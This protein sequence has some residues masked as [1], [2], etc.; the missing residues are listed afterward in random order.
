VPGALA[1]IRAEVGTAPPAGLRPSV[2]GTRNEALSPDTLRLYASN[3]AR[4]AAR[5]AGTVRA[6]SPAA[7]E[8]VIGFFEAGP[9]RAALRRRLAASNRGFRRLVQILLLVPE[10]VIGGGCPA[11]CRA[12]SWAGV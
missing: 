12:K 6:P 3:W 1:P 10:S 9:G 5:C 4:F 2:V 7:P 11:S 8:T